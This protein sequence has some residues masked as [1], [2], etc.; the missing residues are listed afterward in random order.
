V[1]Y[2]NFK[3]LVINRLL[4]CVKNTQNNFLIFISI[5]YICVNTTQINMKTTGVIVTR[6]QT[7]FLHEGH[8]ELIRY[9]KERH[10]KV[11]ILL[12]TSPVKGSTRNPLDFYTR[13]RMVKQSFSEVVVLPLPDFKS[14]VTWS[15]NLDK[16]LTAT[17]SMETFLLYGSRDS[18]IP[19]YSGKF[20][21]EEIPQIGDF[22][23]S[24]LRHEISDKVMDTVDFRSGIIYAYS[25]MYPKTF[26]TV[27]IA[28]FQDQHQRML[29]GY[30]KVE[31]QWRLPGGFSDPSD[32]NY[33]AA[34]L[35]ELQ[36]ECGQIEVSPM[37][38]EKSFKVQDWRYRN[39]TDKIITLLFSCSHV[40][41]QAQGS[42]DL[43]EVRWFPLNEIKEMQR[44]NELVPEHH[45]M[46]DHLLNTYLPE[47]N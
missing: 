42:D 19:Y 39:E 11:V 30:R 35:R 8:F 34:A 41:G 17:F 36:E 18:F 22:T 26:T 12:G 13:E 14:D 27:D 6:F 31:N 9:V 25:N 16:L 15:Q 33:E 23:A 21:V 1:E 5:F 3:Q 4:F 28:L 10:N 7:P 37:R 46:I 47:T 40:F 45:P 20:K 32:E 29:L 43:D 38:Y 2:D 24:Q 44:K